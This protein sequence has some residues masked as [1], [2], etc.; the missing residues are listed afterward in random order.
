MGPVGAVVATHARTGYTA[1]QIMS[2]YSTG[3]N[4]L[5][6]FAREGSTYGEKGR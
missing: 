1:D 2:I 6:R 3:Q 4:A 5:D